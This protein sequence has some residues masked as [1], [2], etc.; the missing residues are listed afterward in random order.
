MRGLALINPGPVTMCLCSGTLPRDLDHPFAAKPGQQTSGQRSLP[1]IKP[2]IINWLL[3]VPPYRRR[4]VG[5]Q[6]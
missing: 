1:W 2:A 3:T 4:S 6:V 5:C